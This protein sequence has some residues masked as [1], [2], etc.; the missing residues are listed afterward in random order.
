MSECVLVNG[1]QVYEQDIPEYTSGKRPDFDSIGAKI[2]RALVEA[3]GDRK[4]VL[5]GISVQEHGKTVDEVV[6]LIT[7]LGTDRTDQQREGRGYRHVDCDFFA[8][9]WNP[10]SGGA[11][12]WVRKF[13]E[14]SIRHGR[15]PLRPDLFIVYDPEQV[16]NITYSK[17][18]KILKDA[19]AFKGPEKKDAL[20]G[21]LRIG[22]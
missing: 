15:S 21:I 16:Q 2:D 6:N 12:I 19:Y 7:S 8:A 5:R 4:L 9:E 17:G 14:G 20:L 11:Q 3:F 22:G 1:K 13:Y 10:A 18:D